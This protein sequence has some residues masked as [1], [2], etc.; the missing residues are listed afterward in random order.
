MP[1]HTDAV[2]RG[3]TGAF[4]YTTTT[5]PTWV[6]I[7]VMHFDTHLRCSRR[8]GRDTLTLTANDQMYLGSGESKSDTKQVRGLRRKDCGHAGAEWRMTSAATCHLSLIYLIPPCW[9]CIEERPV[10]LPWHHRGTSARCAERRIA[11][12]GTCQG[13]HLGAGMIEGFAMTRRGMNTTK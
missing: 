1:Q 11:S 10:S 6:Q 7:S 2:F 13:C 8:Y 4:T 3:I 12:A 9:N 5:F